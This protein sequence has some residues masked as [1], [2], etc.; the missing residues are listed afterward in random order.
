MGAILVRMTS[1]PIKKTA[2]RACLPTTAP[3]SRPRYIKVISL[4][5]TGGVR[6]RRDCEKIRFDICHGSSSTLR[7]HSGSVVAHILRRQTGHQLCRELVILDKDEAFLWPYT[8]KEFGG[9]SFQQTWTYISA[10]F[11][12]VSRGSR[13]S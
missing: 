11:A 9:T 10:V 2:E 13:K 1:L 12:T 5:R 6:I 8:A 7:S 3:A 4:N